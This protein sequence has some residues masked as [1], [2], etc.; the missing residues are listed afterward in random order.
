[1]SKNI[2]TYVDKEMCKN[3]G[4]VCCKENGCAYLPQ[5]FKNMNINYLIEELNK[6]NISI[7]GQPAPFLG[8]TWTYILFLRARN[9]DAPIVD[10]F[11]NGGPCKNLTE[12]GCGLKRNEMPSLGKSVKPTKVGGPCK[13]MLEPVFMTDSWLKY[14]N[15]LKRIIMKI[16][17]EDFEELLISQINERID[18]IKEKLSNNI[19]IT[20]M[21]KQAQSWYKN[22]IVNRP[23]CDIDEVM[24]MNKKI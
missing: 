9:E 3:C 19:E 17:G 10:L 13:Q 11:T 12:T 8:D 15:L 21:E 5:D 1:M 7:S 18:L 4:G 24:K 23:Y 14:Q 22:Y 16:T 20:S 6:G 2:K